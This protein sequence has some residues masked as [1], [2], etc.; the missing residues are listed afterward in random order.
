MEAGIFRRS[1]VVELY[2]MLFSECKRLFVWYLKHNLCSYKISVLNYCFRHLISYAMWMTL[3]FPIW[4]HRLRR[5]VLF[6]LRAS[7]QLAF[8]AP[9]PFGSPRYSIP[10]F[11]STAIKHSCIRCVIT[12]LNFRRIS[13]IKVHKTLFNWDLMHIKCE[14]EVWSVFE[15]HI[16]KLNKKR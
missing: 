14:L 6:S 2:W 3:A 10:T 4:K 1:Y 8:V 5:F 7:Q 15:T 16:F 11:H 13:Q 12:T 9:G